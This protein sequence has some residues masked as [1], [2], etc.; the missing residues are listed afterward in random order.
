MI[1]NV[2]GS[3]FLENRVIRSPNRLIS[4]EGRFPMKEG[5]HWEIKG[6]SQDACAYQVAGG[7]DMRVGVLG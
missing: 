6:F 7:V 1:S 5:I 4:T 2:E 3:H